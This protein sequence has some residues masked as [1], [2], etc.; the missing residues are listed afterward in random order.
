MQPP[1]FGDPVTTRPRVRVNG[2]GP[3]QRTFTTLLGLRRS[4][5]HVRPPTGDEVTP[6]AGGYVHRMGIGQSR[7]L[8]GGGP[9][10]RIYRWPPSAS[11]C[12]LDATLIFSPAPRLEEPRVDLA[13]LPYQRW[14]QTPTTDLGLSAV[15]PDA[16][17]RAAV[18]NEDAATHG[19]SGSPRVGESAAVDT[20][21]EFH[22]IMTF[23]GVVSQTGPWR[24]PY[25]NSIFVERFS[26]K[27][28][29]SNFPQ[30]SVVPREDPR[31]PAASTPRRVRP[32]RGEYGWRRQGL[33]VAVIPSP[34]RWRKMICIRSL[35]NR[36]VKEVRS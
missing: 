16:R 8:D 10:G 17:P 29:P 25:G 5:H 33:D 15:H 4:K 2:D 7:L 23:H 30:I 32:R 13:S 19:S 20:C 14:W 12:P 36:E 26:A 28:S 24:G 22:W 21:G 34:R 35:A 18:Y 3:V 9:H 6:L 31:L 27:P 11:I 1:G